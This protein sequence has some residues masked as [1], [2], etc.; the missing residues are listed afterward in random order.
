MAFYSNEIADV[1]KTFGHKNVVVQMEAEPVKVVP[2]LGL[3]FTC[4][5]EKVPH[6]FTVT[7]RQYKADD[8][9]KVELEPVRHEKFIFG[10]EKFYCSD[11][12]QIWAS[13]NIR[14]FIITLDEH[15]QNYYTEVIYKE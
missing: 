4:G 5:D 9:Y 3:G 12:D 2:L 8:G 10:F 7:E 14:V 13:G 15:H 6:L 1:V 11:F